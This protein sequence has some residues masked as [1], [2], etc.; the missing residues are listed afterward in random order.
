MR[1]TI[2]VKPPL[3]AAD[4]PLGF[5]YRA[6]PLSPARAPFSPLKGALS[7]RAY[8]ASCLPGHPGA[9]YP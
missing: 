9:I 6:P 5:L 2:I 4:E 3:N 1:G 8:I 7:N